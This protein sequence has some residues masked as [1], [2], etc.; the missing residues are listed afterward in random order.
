MYNNFYNKTLFRN[1]SRYLI[2]RPRIVTV[3]D[4][5]YDFAVNYLRDERPMK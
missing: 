5:E 3:I 4:D 2:A 1:Q